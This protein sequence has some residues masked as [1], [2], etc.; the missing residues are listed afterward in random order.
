MSQEVYE[1]M[2]NSTAQM[3]AS[4]YENWGGVGVYCLEF[5]PIN[6]RM[7]ACVTV[8]SRICEIW[9]VANM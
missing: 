7:L 9:D 1:K 4:T 3:A 8:K 2:F 6:T 5:N